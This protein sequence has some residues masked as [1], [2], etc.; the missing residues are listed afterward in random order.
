MSCVPSTEELR[1]FYQIRIAFLTRRNDTESWLSIE[2]DCN[3][4]AVMSPAGA[5]GPSR[6]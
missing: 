2:S 3:V 5:P 6:G 1:Q 4:G